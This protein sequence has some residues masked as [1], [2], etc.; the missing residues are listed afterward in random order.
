MWLQTKVVFDN[1]NSLFILQLFGKEGLNHRESFPLS[2]EDNTDQ[3]IPDKS[4]E[5][6]EGS[7]QQTSSFRGYKEQTLTNFHQQNNESIADLLT[8]IDFT[9]RDM[10]LQPVCYIYLFKHAVT[11]FAVC[12]W[13]RENQ[14]TSTLTSFWIKLKAMRLLW[15][16]FITTK[17]LSGFP[18]LVSCSMHAFHSSKG[19]RGKWSMGPELNW[20]NITINVNV[21]FEEILVL[22]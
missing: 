5:A 18:L 8:K 21:I 20:P 3:K 22:T 17:K 11:Y 9:V 16:I 10:L 7:F 19:T 13:T 6:F 12:L 1:K 2:A 14:Q 15:Q 4:M